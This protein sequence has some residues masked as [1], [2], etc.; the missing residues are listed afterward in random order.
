M[1]Y[2]IDTH[3]LIWYLENNSRLSGKAGA[4]IENQ[5]VQCLVSLASLWEI[6]IKVSL[7]RLE[8][9]ID[10]KRIKELLF[11]L[12]IDILPIEFTHLL[13]VARLPFH[14]KDP[15]DRLLISQAQ[16]EELILISK[17]EHFQSYNIE[18]LW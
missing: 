5:Q 3:A 10:L 13:Q 1:K 2:L 14:H 18:T 16:V 9:G 6:S 11:I 15:F 8:I 4:I 12:G 17:D 7:D